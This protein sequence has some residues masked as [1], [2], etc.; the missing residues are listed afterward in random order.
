M[1]EN[2]I[3]LDI[4]QLNEA[5]KQIENEAIKDYLKFLSFES[6]STDPA[7]ST[8][9]LACSTWLKEYLEK[10]KFQVEVIPTKG[11]PVLLASNCS[12][13]PNKPTLLIYHHYDVQPIDPIAEWSSPPFTPT[14]K[15]GEVY[16]RGAQ[17]NKGQCFYTIQALKI[18][19]KKLGSFPINIKLCIEGEEE[20]GSKGLAD[21]LPEKKELFKADYLAIV[22][23]GLQN[24]E[25]PSVTIGVRGLVTMDMEVEGSYTDL[26][27]GSHGGIAYNPLHALV[28]ILAELRD[29]SGKIVIPGFYDEVVELS[30]KERNHIAFDFDEKQYVELFGI[31]PTGG[32][33]QYAP[34]ERVCLRPT[35]EVNGISGG[36]AGIG[37]KTVIPARAH[38][39]ISCRLVPNQ[40]PVKMGSL[41]KRYLESKAPEGIKVKVDIHPGG[42]TAARANPS[43]K[44]V[45][46]FSQSFSES[47]NKPCQF[48]LDGATIPIGAAL[49][50]A[51]GAEAVLIGLGLPDDQIHAPNEHFGLDR[52]ARGVA[53]M[54]RGITLL[55]EIG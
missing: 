13:G 10:V 45:K 11:Y 28:K 48:I 24:K 18:L 51:S 29:P 44:V 7:Y 22:D 14:I 35:L 16:A 21:I 33:R 20:T 40:D 9:V 31:K 6:V 46:A 26:H 42:G 1:K 30:S 36:Y 4:Q 3:S 54:A 27:S 34:Q 49:A 23:V 32:E 38:A 12:A 17:D 2:V 55:S 39:K 5:Y 19:L 15:N 37:F 43:S 25:S 8:Q 41:V 47:F 53:I 50:Q 52:F